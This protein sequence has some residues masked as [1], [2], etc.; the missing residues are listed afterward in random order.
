MFGLSVSPRYLQNFNKYLRQFLITKREDAEEEG[1][2]YYFDNPFEEEVDSE[3]DFSD[4]ELRDKVRVLHHLCELRLVAPDVGE[5]VKNLDCASL[6]VDPLGVDSVGTTLWYFYGTRL[7][8][9]ERGSD[10]DKS[11]R[12]RRKKHKK[13]KKKRRKRSRESVESVE[14][15][16]SSEAEEEADTQWSVACSTEEDWEELVARY[17]Q[18][19][20]REDRKLYRLLHDC[21][22]PE[23]REMFV[24][25][26]REDKKKMQQQLSRRSSSRVEVL[27]KQQE[28]KDRQLALQ[29]R[30]KYLK[31]RLFCSL[32]YDLPLLKSLVLSLLP[33]LVV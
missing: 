20:R 9:E 33:S 13:L 12:K 26:R 31:T 30:C 23:I 24:E 3:K 21:F 19:E 29:V 32:F 17:K 15:V 2:E 16:A 10:L 5:R 8:K 25:K 28:E 18:S 1:H 4:L 6:R 7:Y 14:S 22:L 11:E 27:K